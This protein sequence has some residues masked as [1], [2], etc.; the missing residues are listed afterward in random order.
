M[1]CC[2]ADALVEKGYVI[3][4][5]GV[6]AQ[7]GVGKVGEGLGEAEVVSCDSEIA[8]REPFEQAAEADV[9]FC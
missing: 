9:V 8:F 2:R 4:V 6:G 5:D 7:G 1:L 3:G